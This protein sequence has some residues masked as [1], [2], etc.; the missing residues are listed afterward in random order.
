MTRTFP[1]PAEDPVEPPAEFLD[2]ASTQPVSLV[3]LPTGDTAWLVTGYAEVRAALSD[4]RLSR[5]LANAP[6]APRLRPARPDSG[7]SLFSLDPPAHTRLRRLVA[8]AFTA[9]HMELLRPRVESV[10]EGLLDGIEQAGPPADLVAGLTQPLP[11]VI[12]CDLLGVPY[13]DRA[14]FRSWTERILTLT[15]HSREQ[16]RQASIDLSAY[17]A[18]LVARK[19]VA[20]ADDLLSALIKVQERDDALSDAELITF[21]NTLLTAGHH[22]TAG[23]MAASLLTLLRHPSQARALRE[24][25]ERIG[26]SVEELLRYAVPAVNG[27]LMRIAT[28]DLD[29]GGVR[30]R[31]GEGV[32]PAIVAANRDSRVYESPGTLRLDRECPGSPHLTFGHGIH[33]CLGAPLARLE[34]GVAVGAVLRRLPGLRLAV[35]ESDLT[36]ADGHTH[37]T[38]DALPVVWDRR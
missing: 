12:I 17:L 23:Q 25:P 35:P 13:K 37:R 1:F 3:V 33:Y 9:R 4:R 11:M 18:D 32:L 15:A 8:K 38:L 19:R 2:L 14:L 10:T 34:L 28:E 27:G 29:L 21:G 36:W 30:I 26:V 7:T 31:A 16:A 24:H 5:R 6:E 22:T 20:P